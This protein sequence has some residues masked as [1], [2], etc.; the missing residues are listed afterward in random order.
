MMHDWGGG[1]GMF[2]GP[3]YMIA[4]L[5][6]LVAAV[7]LIVRWMGVAGPGLSPPARTARDILDERFARGE[8]DHDE[9]EKRRRALNN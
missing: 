6:I 7:L 8:I 5:L 9:Y 1:W 3:L 2:F 4:W